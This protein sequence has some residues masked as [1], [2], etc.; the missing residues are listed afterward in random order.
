MIFFLKKDKYL[1]WSDIVEAEV[2]L[3]PEGEIGQPR[4]LLLYIYDTEHELLNRMLENP[5]LHETIVCKLQQI[6]HQC[7]PFVDMFRQ[8]PLRL[9]VHECCNSAC[10]LVLIK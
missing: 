7:N 9:D 1:K 10:V 8:L 6:L 3:F 2:K 5:E 4:Y